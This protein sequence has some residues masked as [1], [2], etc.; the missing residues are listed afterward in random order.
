MHLGL[1]KNN[2][3]GHAA[4][5][6]LEFLD[7]FLRDDLT[8]ADDFIYDMHLYNSLNFMDYYCND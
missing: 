4:E 7:G 5:W 3:G 8:L 6:A 2:L 1:V